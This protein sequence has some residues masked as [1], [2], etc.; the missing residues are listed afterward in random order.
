M[1]HTFCPTQTPSATLVCVPFSTPLRIGTIWEHGL[2]ETEYGL[3]ETKCGP[4]ECDAIWILASVARTGTDV[5]HA[6]GMEV[7]RC[8][9]PT[10][11]LVGC[12]G[13]TVEGSSMVGYSM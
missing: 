9:V 5:R 7:T 13:L 8:W 2:Y 3:Y 4:D 10:E 1:L 11:D 6:D 12:Q